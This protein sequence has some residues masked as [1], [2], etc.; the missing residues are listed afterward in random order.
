[1]WT[2]M[3]PHPSATCASSSS[4]GAITAI[5]FSPFRDRPTAGR[6]ATAPT[7][8]RCS[9]RRSRQLTAYFDARAQGVRPAARAAGTDFQQRVWDAAARDRL[10]RDRVV[11]RDRAPARHDQRRLPRGRPGQRPQPDPDRDPV[12]P[13]HRRQRHPHRL[14]RRPRAQAAAAGAGAGRALLSLRTRPARSRTRAGRGRL[15]ERRKRQVAT[16]R[17]ET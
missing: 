15:L 8:T 4:D 10:R 3:R 9:P 16:A 7:T 17:L 13:G 1:M 14:R 11:R 2:V 6:A 12:P 5:E